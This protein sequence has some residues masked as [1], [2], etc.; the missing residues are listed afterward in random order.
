MSAPIA[1]PTGTLEWR[2][3]KA[4]LRLSLGSF[5]RRMLTLSTCRTQAEAEERR[6]LLCRL[7]DRLVA[8]GQIV[9]GFP[10]LATAATRDG[11]ALEDVVKAL[12]KVSKGE[13][14]ARP[15]G[16]TTIRELAKQWTSGELAKVHPDHVKEKRTADTDEYRLRRHVLPIVGEVPVVR[17]KLDHAQEVMRHI[18]ADRS[19]LTRRH[20]AQLMHRL[21]SMAVFPLCIITANPLPRGFLPKPGRDKAKAYLYPDED[22]KLLAC[23]HVPLCDRISYGFLN[24]EGMRASEA[25]RLE[26][27]DVD[28]ARGAVTLDTN[29]TDEPRA[30]ALG[31]DVVRALVAWRKLREAQGDHDPRV[32]PRSF[33][34]AA[35]R[36]R[37]HLEAAKVERKELF[38]RSTS[39][40][41]IR[42]HDTRATFTTIALANGRTE[43]WVA[44]R[45]GHKSSD[46]IATYRRA[47]RTV[48]EL[49]LGG[50]APLDTSIP[51][52][53]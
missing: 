5:G 48:M 31:L 21:L 35:D 37:A 20:V 12:D 4:R 26:W 49:G 39:R 24:R 29:K 6:A 28:L 47:A 27:S 13:A 9:I 25:A 44:D 15:T 42:L 14:R 17:F 19:V 32:F 1:T 43:T 36:F 45:T 22:Q 18:P 2:R 51:E 46:Q 53:A 30:W 40:R 23:V 16:E 33:D 50:L 52:L 41:P 11:R 7:A 10:L 8:S 34:H 3:G 38:E